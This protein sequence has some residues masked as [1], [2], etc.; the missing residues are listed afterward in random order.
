MIDMSIGMEVDLEKLGENT[1]LDADVNALQL[2]VICQKILNA[3]MKSHE[4]IPKQFKTL[5]A[6]LNVT[7][8]QSFPG[9]DSAVWNA[10]GGFYFLRF[11]GPGLFFPTNLW[12]NSGAS[13]PKCSKT[14]YS[15]SKSD[16]KFSKLTTSWK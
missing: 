4:Y 11:V 7:I 15:N 3:I 2:Q 16:P 6:K 12:L 13:T 14:I 9:D 10:I 5:F 8:D 1:E